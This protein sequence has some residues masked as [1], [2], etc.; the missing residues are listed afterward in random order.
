VGCGAARCGAQA[1]IVV[2][3]KG[4]QTVNRWHQIRQ[5][6]QLLYYLITNSLMNSE[7]SK[8]VIGHLE[9][10]RA[11]LIGTDSQGREHIS[12]EYQELSFKEGIVDMVLSI[13]QQELEEDQLANHAQPTAGQKMLISA[14]GYLSDMAQ[15]YKP[16][17]EILLH[18][19]SVILQLKNCRG[20][21]VAAN[22]AMALIPVFRIASFQAMVRE[23]HI[24]LLVKLMLNL[25]EAGYY[26]AEF[27]DLL[28]TIASSH[29]NEVELSVVYKNQSTIITQLMKD[30][31]IGKDLLENRD[32]LSNSVIDGD[33]GDEVEKGTLASI[34]LDKQFIISLVE[35]L[36]IC[37]AG[38]N[39]HVHTVATSPRA[40]PACTQRL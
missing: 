32:R 35:L 6:G 37:G 40:P 16:M 11:N 28:Q 7:C 19:M 1:F 27:L 15:D 8:L 12:P 17:Q 36:A 4:A 39:R 30:G 20:P 22:V 2:A 33:G 26:V 3:D 13:L 18:E 14:L 23:S 9:K 38:E 29:D 31:R 34:Q 24:I 21:L 10:L 5:E 25:Y